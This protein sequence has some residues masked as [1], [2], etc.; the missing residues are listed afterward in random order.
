VPAIRVGCT[1]DVT[2]WTVPG[3]TDGMPLTLN[4][5]IGEPGCEVPLARYMVNW[6]VPLIFS[7]ATE[8]LFRTDDV[9][10]VN[11]FA[12][13][14][15]TL[16]EGDGLPIPRFGLATVVLP[17]PNV[18]AIVEPVTDCADPVCRQEKSVKKQ[19]A[20]VTVSASF[21]FLCSVINI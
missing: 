18:E 4:D 1:D 9:D 7:T 12:N 16:L 14:F 10:G 17:G 8:M 15:P 19:S 13:S 6:F 3:K 21:D 11:E 20:T 5:S 2:V